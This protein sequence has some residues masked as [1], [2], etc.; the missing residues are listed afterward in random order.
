MLKC[1]AL[2]ERILRLRTTCDTTIPRYHDSDMLF[3]RKKREPDNDLVKVTYNRVRNIVSRNIVKAK[4]DHYKSY[5]DTS[6]SNVELNTQKTKTKRGKKKARKLSIY[7][8]NINGFRTKSDSLEGILDKLQPDLLCLCETKVGTSVT[9]NKYLQKLGYKGISRCSKAGQGGLLIAGKLDSIGNVVDVT[10]SPLLNI[11]VGRVALRGGQ[12]RIILCHAPQETEPVVTR[13]EFFEELAVEVQRGINENDIVMLMG[14]LNSKIDD[15]NNPISGNGKLLMNMVK[16]HKLDIV[17]N[18]T[19]CIGK[20][21]HVIRT[22]GEVSRL[23]Y[24]ITNPVCNEKVDSMFIDEATLLTPF[25]VVRKEV[26]LS[27]HNSIV[28]N[29]RAEPQPK[30]SKYNTK[31]TTTTSWRLEESGL[32][33]LPTICESMMQDCELQTYTTQEG[34]NKFDGICNK[35][36]DSCFR[37]IRSRKNSRG[38]IS[39]I[40]T[41]YLGMYQK[42]VD[43]SKLGKA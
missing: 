18:S 23:D 39:K 32:D 1:R 4:R 36:M 26:V 24:V 30:S 7:Y 13:E 21:T 3:A 25:R 5:F 6:R 35:I 19:K 15:L 14:D 42:V 37:R 40:N 28:V 12:W 34:Y 17:N 29:I 38:V 27:D 33:K 11:I 8:S 43:F 9:T 20:W 22:T 10:S 31:Q 2:I 16:E 41:K